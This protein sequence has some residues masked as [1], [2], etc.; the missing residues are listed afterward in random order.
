MPVHMVWQCY[1]EHRMDQAPKRPD[2]RWS[3][4]GLICNDFGRCVASGAHLL[5]IPLWLVMTQTK[6]LCQ[7]KVCQLG[8]EIFFIAAA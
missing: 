4:I 7:T 2:I 6:L 3:A 8:L 5:V 1:S